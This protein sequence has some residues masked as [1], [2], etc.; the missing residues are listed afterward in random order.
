MKKRSKNFKSLQKDKTHNSKNLTQKITTRNSLLIWLILIFALTFIV[1]N[2]NSQQFYSG[3]DNL[4]TILLP[5]SI[6]EHKRIDLNIFFPEYILKSD[7]PSLHYS[8][9][10]KNGSVYAEKTTGMALFISPIFYVIFKSL[11][12]WNIDPKY[13][14]QYA[15]FQDGE[16]QL[17]LLF[18]EK[19]TASIIAAITVLIIFLICNLIFKDKIYSLLIS[20]IYAFGT[21]HWM[22]SSQALWVHG[23]IE[24][25]LSLLLLCIL[26]YENTK[27]DRYIYFASFS[28]GMVSIIRI[29]GLLY[30]IFV[31]LYFVKYYR[32]KIPKYLLFPSIMII[33]YYMFNLIALKSFLGGYGDIYIKPF[34]LFPIDEI[35]L[36][37]SG[38]FISPGRGLFFYT[39]ILIFSFIGI[40]FLIKN[41]TYPRILYYLLP[42]ALGIIF[43]H[44]VYSDNPNYLKWYG[45]H[46]WGPRYFVDV[47][48]ILIIYLGISIK[49]SKNLID[50][51]RN[52][53]IL[54]QLFLFILTLFVILSVFSQY[55][56]AFYYKG[57]WDT[58]PI[59]IDE[60]PK[61]VWDIYDNPIAV[62]L[63]TGQRETINI[64][65]L[66]NKR[67]VD[68]KVFFKD[69]WYRRENLN[70][71]P[72]RYLSNNATLL[73]LSK[74]NISSNPELSFLS[75]YKPR[76][77]QVYLDNKLIHQ[78]IIETSFVRIKIPLDLKKGESLLRFYAPDGCQRPID[79]PEIN[80]QDTRCLSFAIKS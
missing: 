39:P 50:V 34:Y 22:T 42:A 19:F 10:L 9:R 62:E 44:S 61:R 45:G 70:S 59:N 76:T 28:A 75:F 7:N 38:M 11:Y 43:I 32:N 67:N 6:I 16:S 5:F 68:G 37:F 20:L 51:R 55:V 69:N 46:G 35:I 2:I 26:L 40:Y 52:K 79:I 24:F 56:G 72:I 53:K 66:L 29:D 18:T 1:Y 54:S 8:L 73:L 36:A 63:R 49:E 60:N 41:K 21:N 48:P 31:L 14:F 23:G 58:Q 64:Q 71:T 30:F 15:E 25:W 33:I 13:L 65:E 4:P 17:Y 47:L 3:G 12:P 78:Q 57:Y 80:N 27:L 77:I 74:R